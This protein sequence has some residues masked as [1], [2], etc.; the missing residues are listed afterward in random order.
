[1]R[2]VNV[3]IRSVSRAT[4]VIGT[5]TELLLRWTPATRFTASNVTACSFLRGVPSARRSFCLATS[6]AML[7]TWL[8]WSG[9]TML[10]VTVAKIATSSCRGMRGV[11]MGPGDAGVVIR[12]R[13]ACCVG[14]VMEFVWIVMVTG[15]GIPRNISCLLNCK[16]LE[17]SSRKI[18]TL[19]V[20]K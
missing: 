2:P 7:F 4:R 6:V 9:A 5:W 1:M 17:Q 14:P 8:L 12:W 13:D 15:P 20:K 18:S 19:S 16:V 11:G 10:N 3:T